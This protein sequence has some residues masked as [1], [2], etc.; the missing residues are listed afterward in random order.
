MHD[1]ASEMRGATSWLRDASVLGDKY[2]KQLRG[3]AVEWRGASAEVRYAA[4]LLSAQLGQSCVARLR[5]RVTRL[6]SWVTQLRFKP[7]FG[8]YFSC[9][10]KNE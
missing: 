3:A 6:C 5:R 7:N 10:R 4:V 1:A 9:N 2:F 8:F